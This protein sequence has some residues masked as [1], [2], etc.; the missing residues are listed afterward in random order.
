MISTCIR[1]SEQIRI[2]QVS[3]IMT[4][5][6]TL[7]T[8]AAGGNHGTYQTLTLLAFKYSDTLSYRF[9]SIAI[10]K[11]NVIYRVPIKSHIFRLQPGSLEFSLYKKLRYPV[12]HHLF[13]TQSNHPL[14]ITP[15]AVYDPISTRQWSKFKKSYRRHGPHEKGIRIVPKKD[16][17]ILSASSLHF[18]DSKDRLW[19]TACF[20]RIR[21]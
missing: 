13:S 15:Y 11:Q 12:H 8:V 1:Y 10:D 14:V 3:C 2:T 4:S 5:E 17:R 21:R 9:L 18:L 7:L 19:M 16:G 20:T 6:Y